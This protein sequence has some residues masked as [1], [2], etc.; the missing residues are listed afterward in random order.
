MSYGSRIPSRAK[1]LSAV[2]MYGVPPKGLRVQITETYTSKTIAPRGCSK[3]FF[4]ETGQKRKNPTNMCSGAEML[5]FFLV[6]D[7]W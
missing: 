7:T 6:I 4:I 1:I 3:Q 5:E 2:S